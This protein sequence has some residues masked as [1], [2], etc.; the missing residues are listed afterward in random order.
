[1]GQGFPDF[2]PDDRLIECV[3]EALLGPHNQYA[4]MAGVPALRAAISDKIDNLYGH[5]YDPESEITVTSGASEALNAT[6]TEIGRAHVELQSLMRISYAV[7]CLKKKK[8]S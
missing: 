1:M 4:P 5:R 3:H 2:S 8:K 6:I 7:F